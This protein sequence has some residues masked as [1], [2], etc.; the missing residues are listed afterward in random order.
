MTLPPM[1][2]GDAAMVFYT[3]VGGTEP[4]R[5]LRTDRLVTLAQVR[6][7]IALSLRI[8]ALHYRSATFYQIY[9]HIR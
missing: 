3:E 8:I 9:S 4:S 7:P 2:K 6:E 1:A 5:M